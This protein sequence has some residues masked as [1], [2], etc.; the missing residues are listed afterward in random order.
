MKLF[1][2]FSEWDIGFGNNDC[3]ESES[4]EIVTAEVKEMFSDFED[5]LEMTFEEAVS[6]GLIQIEEK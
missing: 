5:E 4:L 3:F 6:D 2:V 1:S